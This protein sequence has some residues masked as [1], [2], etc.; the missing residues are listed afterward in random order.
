[1]PKFCLFLLLARYSLP[2]LES[3]NLK[4]CSKSLQH[5]LLWIIANMM[6]V[7]R[8]TSCVYLNV[9]LWPRISL[10][11][12]FWIILKCNVVVYVKGKDV[13]TFTIKEIYDPKTMNKT[14]YLILPT[15]TPSF[16]ELVALWEKNMGN[17]ME[18]VYVL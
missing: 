8:F 13:G 7:M 6:I 11:C 2:I 10:L 12:F 17:T 18:K 15:N 16:N 4:I 14:L 9:S 1:M 5:Y 3:C